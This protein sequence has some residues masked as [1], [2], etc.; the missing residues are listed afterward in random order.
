M[1][2]RNKKTG[3]ILEITKAILGERNKSGGLRWSHHFGGED[4]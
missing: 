1:K 2:I 3:E 4:E